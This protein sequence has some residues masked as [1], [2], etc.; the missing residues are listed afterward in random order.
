MSFSLTPKQTGLNH[1]LAGPQRHTL[2]VGGA[3]SGKTFLLTRAVLVRALRAERSRHVMARLRA[4][5]ARSSLWLDTIPKVA[6]LCF[7]GV[8]LRDRRQDGYVLLPNGSEVWVAG[9]DDKDR[10]EK[11]LGQ[12]FATV[13]VNEASQ[14]PLG[15]VMVLLTRLA[16]TV[17]GL[18]QRAYYD[19]N[20]VGRGHWS[21]RMFVQ[22]VDPETRR[23]LVDPENYEHAFLNPLD[24]ARNLSRAYLDSLDRMPERKRRRFFLGEYVDEVDG[25]LWL[26]ETLEAARIDPADVPATLREVVVAVDPSGTAGEEDVRSDE[27]G[28]VVAGRDDDGLAY[29]LAD[30]TC[31]LP[32]E[33][34]ARAVVDAYARFAADR[35]VAEANFGGD[36]VRAVIQSAAGSRIPVRLVRSSRGKALRA[37]PVSALY[38][39][40]DPTGG[41]EPGRVRHAAVGLDALE[42]EMLGFSTSGYVGLRSPNRCDALVFALRDLCLGGADDGVVAAPIVLTAGRTSPETRPHRSRVDPSAAPPRSDADGAMGLAEYQRL[43]DARGW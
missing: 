16:Q 25:A 32:P 36:M 31:R 26:L 33:G 3:R 29:V 18:T 11:I 15:S 40:A 20:P 38:G 17:P 10:V 43:V 39:R 30:L 1:L 4:N 24:N 14:V 8:A 41:W 9:L 27:V 7:P 2:F 12:E 19:L 28:I 22:K 23:P 21:Y 6:R 13:Y 42:E 34:W 35:V 37:E 5:A